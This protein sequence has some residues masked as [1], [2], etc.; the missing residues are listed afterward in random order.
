MAKKIVKGVGKLAG[1]VVGGVLGLG[2]K[3]KKSAA[4]IEGQPII[5]PLAEN[6]ETGQILRRRA[7]Q[8]PLGASTILGGLS[9]TLGG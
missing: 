8:S 4:P 5:T 7:K 2:G 3:K 9:G 6:T 1:G